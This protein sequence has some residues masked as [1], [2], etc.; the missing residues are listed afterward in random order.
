MKNKFLFGLFG[1]LVF[2][3]GLVGNSGHADYAMNKAEFVSA[4]DGENP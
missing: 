4:I 3:M 1:S 2:V